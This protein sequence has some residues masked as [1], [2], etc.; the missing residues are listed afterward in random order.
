MHHNCIVLRFLNVIYFREYLCVIYCLTNKRSPIHY[1]CAN[2][3][4]L[5][6]SLKETFL[7]T[8]IYTTRFT[9]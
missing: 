4:T 3:L 5:K 8:Y 2:E 7:Y 1:F 6:D 9:S